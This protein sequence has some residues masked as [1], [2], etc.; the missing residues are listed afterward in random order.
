MECSLAEAIKTSPTPRSHSLI[1]AAAGRI[2]TIC[3]LAQRRAH[4]PDQL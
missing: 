1:Y 4:Q 3:H 2:L